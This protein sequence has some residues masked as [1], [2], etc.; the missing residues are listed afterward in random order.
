MRVDFNGTQTGYRAKPGDDGTRGGDDDIT[1]DVVSG[2]EIHW[3]SIEKPQEVGLVEDGTFDL[4]MTVN[5]ENHEADTVTRP[6]II[7]KIN[8]GGVIHQTEI[9]MKGESRENYKV[10]AKGKPPGGSV[11]GPFENF[12]IEVSIDSDVEE[13]HHVTI[14]NAGG[15]SIDEIRKDKNPNP[16]GIGKEVPIALGV[17]GAGTILYGMTG[18]NQ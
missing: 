5:I 12:F 6:L 14:T 17:I 4:E 15:D 13:C 2:Q 1:D 11:S 7:R 16:G 18:G 8:G 9:T 10:K 3:C